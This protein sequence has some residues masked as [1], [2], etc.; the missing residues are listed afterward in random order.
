MLI[1]GVALFAGAVLSLAAQVNGRQA[2]RVTIG[3]VEKGE[4][5]AA[6]CWKNA[7]RNQ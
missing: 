7:E 1:L 5:V 6:A 2:S 4:R 3:R